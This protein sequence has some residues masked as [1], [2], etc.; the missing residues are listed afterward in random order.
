MTAIPTRP[1]RHMLDYTLTRM[2]INNSTACMLHAH[3]SRYCRTATVRAKFKFKS[4]VGR[5]KRRECSLSQRIP[6]GVA[7]P[8]PSFHSLVLSPLR[9]HTAY[10]MWYR[11]E[12][13]KMIHSGRHTELVL[14]RCMLFPLFPFK[15]RSFF[16]PHHLPQSHLVSS[17]AV[18]LVGP[19][20]ARADL[21]VR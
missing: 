14:W 11:L 16:L 1:V 15:S 13:L 20:Q 12:E 19:N 3:G 2:C 21:L 5:S 6:G 7:F 10:S 17:V 18:W 4:R 9:H 8:F